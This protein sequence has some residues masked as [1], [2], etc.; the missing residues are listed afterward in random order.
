M[1]ADK[2]SLAQTF[3]P[4]SAPG[5][6]RLSEALAMACYNARGLPPAAED[7]LCDEIRGLVKSGA[8]V[9]A[10]DYNQ[11]PALF[12]LV[13]NR[14]LKAAEC[15][16]DLGADV[17]AAN[18]D[19]QTPMVRAAKNG[20]AA[21]MRL[22]LSRKADI[23]AMEDD[24]HDS[25][26]Y[27]FEMKDQKAARDCLT[28]LTDHGLDVGYF[29][30]KQIY[31]SLLYLAD[32]VPKVRGAVDLKLAVNDGDNIRIRE[33]MDAGVKPDIGVHY[34]D[35]AALI[36]ASTSNNTEG[37]ELLIKAGADVNKISPMVRKTPLLNAA[38]HGRKEACK[39]LIDHGADPYIEF[40]RTG[41]GGD[42]F[43]FAGIS[44]TPGMVEYLREIVADREWAAAHPPP[45]DITTAQSVTISKPL[46][47]R[48]GP[49]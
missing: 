47:F 45:P 16:L 1:A 27:C 42:A 29:T 36:Y 13:E 35:N 23:R 19:K 15:L 11:R 6:D 37:M 18:G 30:E 24:G 49:A 21:M 7:K 31:D 34:G 5:P 3:A 10:K 48:Q 43:V 22:L 17:D 46:K 33:L 38:T 44:R 28:A 4:A 40:D 20:D 41:V 12:L 25:E 9:N 39:V 8:D 14:C 2:N 32:A 26:L